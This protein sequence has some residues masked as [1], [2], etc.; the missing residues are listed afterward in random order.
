[1]PALLRR[2]LLAV[3]AVVLLVGMAGASAFWYGTRLGAELAASGKNP[4]VAGTDFG[5]RTDQSS[6]IAEALAPA[7]RDG[8]TQALL[9]AHLFL[10]GCLAASHPTPGFCGGV[11]PSGEILASATWAVDK[12]D[13]LGVP[14]HFCQQLM[15]DVQAACDS[16]GHPA[17]P[18][19]A[20]I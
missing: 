18:A 20:A 3:G 12:C 15:R 19:S 4:F 7:R 8:G 13:A 10:K 2:I 5:K 6:C 9:E 17:R 11:P 1:M 14:G 16:G